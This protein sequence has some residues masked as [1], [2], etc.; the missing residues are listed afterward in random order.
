MKTITNLYAKLNIGRQLTRTSYVLL[1]IVLTISSL[2]RSQPLVLLIVTLVPL[3]IF[4]PG[5]IK[6]NYKSI[7]LLCFVTLPYFI[8]SVTNLFAPT[9]SGFDIVELIIVV[10]LF[11]ATMMFSRW[12]QYSLYQKEEL[13]G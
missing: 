8:V 13:E 6:E 7:S 11:N 5:L 12:K 1:L 4:V 9:R 10:V 3:L 2:V